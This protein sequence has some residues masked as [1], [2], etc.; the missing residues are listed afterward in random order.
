MVDRA[1]PDPSM[2]AG[3]QTLEPIVAYRDALLAEAERSSGLAVV[4][5]GLPAV[6]A[7]RDFAARHADRYSSVAPPELVAAAVERSRRGGPVFLGA[8]TAALLGAAFPS[9]VR[10][11][12][13]PR[14]NVKLVGFPV[15]PA[16]DPHG[17]ELAGRDDVGAM[18]AL[19]AMT[20]VV[21]ADGPTVRSAT[22]ALA[23]RAGPAYLRLP[24]AD[25]PAVTDG[26]FA[27]GRAHE[28]RAGADLAIVALGP[29]LA[30]ALQ[31]AEELARVGLSVRV[32]DVASVKP[33][34]EAA[35]LRAARDTGALLVVEAAPLSTGVGTLVAA[36]TAENLPVP[37]RRVGFPDVVPGGGAASPDGEQGVSLDRVRDEAW[38]LLRLRGR[39]A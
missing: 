31:A 26:T 13:V 7:P 37:V 4:E 30:L 21:P 24:P 39:I 25:A 33:F 11:L 36:M 29:A 38:E 5:G 20:V 10:S 8:P 15:E 18:R 3:A 6:L 35:I 23:G 1:P 12:V 34:D 28:L 17:D 2:T 27:V 14:A 32:L 9:I 16:P 19:P 22:A